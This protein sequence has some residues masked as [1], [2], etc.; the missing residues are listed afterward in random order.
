[1]TLFANRS[2]NRDGQGRKAQD[3]IFFVSFSFR[4]SLMRKLLS[5]LANMSQGNRNLILFLAG[6][7]FKK[8]GGM[9]AGRKLARV[10][11]PINVESDFL[12]E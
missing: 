1:V 7:V 4:R 12:P 5:L 11:G 6:R 9:K 3:G 2:T 8:Q 10:P